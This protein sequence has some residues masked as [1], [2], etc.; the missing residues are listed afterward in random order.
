MKNIKVVIFIHKHDIIGIILLK[1]LIRGNP[2]TY[3]VYAKIKQK[4]TGRR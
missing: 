1:I 3:K 2:D 4:K